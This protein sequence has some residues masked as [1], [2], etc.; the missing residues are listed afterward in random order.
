MD[1]RGVSGVI[2]RCWQIK[3]DICGKEELIFGRREDGWKDF[4]L[5]D[6]YKMQMEKRNPSTVCPQC[7]ERIGKFIYAMLNEYKEGSPV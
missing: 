1:H 2:Q 5:G 7:A 4:V 6:F 3:C